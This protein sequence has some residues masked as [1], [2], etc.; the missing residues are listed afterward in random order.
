[1]SE[2]TFSTLTADK[3][4]KHSNAN[5]RHLNFHRNINWEAFCKWQ[6]WAEII[7][8]V[9]SRHSFAF[10]TDKIITELLQLVT[11]DSA[12]LLKSSLYLLNVLGICADVDKSALHLLFTTVQSRISLIAM[13]ETIGRLGSEQQNEG[14]NNTSDLL[15]YIPTLFRGPINKCVQLSVMKFFCR[16]PPE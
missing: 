11:K 5:N 10:T 4:R 3:I 12:S 16:L 14:Q 1:M 13:S 15:I 7:A 8:S 2:R 9:F 6:Q